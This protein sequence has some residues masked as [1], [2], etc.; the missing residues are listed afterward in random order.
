MLQ[1]ANDGT[2]LSITLPDGRTPLANFAPGSVSDYIPFD[3]DRSTLISVAVV[4]AGGL[5]FTREWAVPP[6]APGYHTAAV[7]GSGRDNTLELIFIDEDAVCEGGLE[8]GSCV[9]LVNNIKGSPSLTLIANSTPVVE[10]AHYRQAVVG[11]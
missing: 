11:G 5:T 3:T 10:D 8:T 7:V 9:I 6:L 4:P 2:S 1:L